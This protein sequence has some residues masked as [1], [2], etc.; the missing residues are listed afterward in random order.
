MTPNDQQ[1]RVL[2]VATRTSSSWSVSGIT[3]AWSPDG[4]KIAY[5]N[6]S[7][8]VSLVTP[9]GTVQSLPVSGYTYGVLAWSPDS[10]W[11]IAYQSTGPV[12]I[13]AATGTTLPLTYAGSKLPASMK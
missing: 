13:D 11:V 9:D 8:G 3:P 5:R 6:S 7:G 1:I 2:D 4:T 10:K 12:L